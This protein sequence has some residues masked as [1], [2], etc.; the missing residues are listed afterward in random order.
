MWWTTIGVARHRAVLVETA[1]RLGSR[2]QI[3]AGRGGP[4]HYQTIVGRV[5]RWR[6]EDGR[7]LKRWTPSAGVAIGD[8]QSEV[9]G[10]GAAW[11]ARRTST[12]TLT[13]L[14][15][16]SVLR[17]EVCDRLP[18]MPSWSK[19]FNYLGVTYYYKCYHDLVVPSFDS[20]SKS[21]NWMNILK[22]LWEGHNR[23]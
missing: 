13:L 6:P 9:R 17:T 14:A 23:V 2:I 3:L 19:L 5:K 18:L 10:A 8:S 21:H 22:W 20:L 1:A 7:R 12:V 11:S 4:L 16:S 15:R